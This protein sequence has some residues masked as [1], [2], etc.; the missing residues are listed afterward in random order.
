VDRFRN[1]EH[2]LGR[3][4]VEAQMSSVQSV[5]RAF[6]VLRC[7]AGGPAGVSDIAERAALPKSTVSRLLSTL[8]TL[9]AVE[10]VS[11]GGDYRVGAMLV[12][13][14]SAALPSRSLVDVGRPYVQELAAALDEAAG[15]SVLDGDSVVYLDSTEST[16]AVQLK[17]WTGERLPLHVVSSGLVLLAHAP[18]GVAERYLRRPLER[19]TPRTV[20]DAAKLRKRLAAIRKRP[21]EWVLAEFSEEVNSVAAPVCGANGSVVAAVHAHGPSYRFPPPGEAEEIGAIV[22]AVAGKI[23]ARL[24]DQAARLPEE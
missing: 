1:V 13:L 21:V 3:G 19:F 5:E 23:S 7:L 24:A 15:L 10:Q 4:R 6:S 12:D 18:P 14:A 11:A 16:R 2:S 22:A 17:D 20:V 8:Q 9:G